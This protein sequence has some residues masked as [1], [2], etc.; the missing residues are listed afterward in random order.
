MATT[1]NVLADRYEVK[2]KLGEGGMGIVYLAHDRN[3]KTNVVVKMPL[4]SAMADPGFIE[5]FTQEIRALVSMRHPHIVKIIDV[6]SHGKRPFAVM[7]YLGGGSLQDR[8]IPA[9]PATL[10][11]WLM[12]I[13]SAL[14]FVHVRKILHRD[15]KPANILF[16]ENG[17]AFLSDFGVAKVLAD[18]PEETVREALT[19]AGLI[20][21]TAEYMAPE[22]VRARK[23]VDG[24]ADQY[25]LAATVYEVLMGRPP[26]V[27]S[28]SQAVMVAQVTDPVPPLKGLAQPLASTVLRG[29][30]KNPEGRYATCTEFALAVI[31][32]SEGIPPIFPLSTPSGTVKISSTRI[33]TPASAQ[34]AATR[35]E[36]SPTDRFQDVPSPPSSNKTS[37]RKKVASQQQEPSGK[38]QMLALMS[39]IMIMVLAAGGFVAFLFN[40]AGYFKI[41]QQ[42]VAVIKPGDKEVAKNPSFRLLEVPPEINLSAGSIKRL[43]VKLERRSYFGPVGVT[44]PN[45]PEGVKLRELVFPPRIDTGELVLE[46]D[47]NAKPFNRMIKLKIKGG[48]EEYIAE[49]QLVIN[50]QPMLILETITDS[51]KLQAGIRQKVRIKLN[52]EN[53]DNE[54]VQLV[55]TPAKPIFLESIPKDI[56][57]GDNSI[58]L[59]FHANP[60]PKTKKLPSNR[61]VKVQ[62]VLKN[63]QTVVS[64][65]ISF[66]VIVQP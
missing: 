23:D 66:N 51:V 54:T 26:F 33:E 6:G 14:D 32:A 61:L 56:A 65:T 19:C 1:T 4:L 59:V 15:V 11:N 12:P 16:D 62:A 3:L 38:S 46:V 39:I 47:G 20:I 9:P 2:K 24:R 35:I 29:L 17:F 10:A 8:G 22:L 34:V 28:E 36:A 13:A 49:T 27:A 5:R 43:L 55:F 25:A 48:D 63:N 31:A 52:R 45:M 50:S 18:T 58:E 64:N 37:K 41:K 30:A 60:T 53:C 21:G 42:E 40:Q 44:I 7:E 57:P